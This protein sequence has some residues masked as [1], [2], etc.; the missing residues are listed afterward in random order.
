MH[1]GPPQ[2]FGTLLQRYRAAAGLTQEELAERSGV[3]ARTVSDL[4]RGLKRTPRP[5]TL[6]LLAAALG[7]VAGERAAFTAAAHPSAAPPPP[8]G[9]DR[10]APRPPA[11]ARHSGAASLAKG[12]LPL[13]GWVR[14]L[15]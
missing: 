13:V 9:F 8:R 11:D 1:M 7:L 2:T 15:A 6:R 3:S 5:D 4:E 10:A 14:E 12:A